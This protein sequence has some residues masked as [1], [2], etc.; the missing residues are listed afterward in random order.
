MNAPIRVPGGAPVSAILVSCATLLAVVLVQPVRANPLPSGQVIFNVQAV[1][2]SF[3]SHPPLSC[4]DAVQYTDQEGILEFDFYVYNLVEPEYTVSALTAEL[5]WPATWIVLDWEVCGSGSGEVQIGSG[6]GSLDLNWP[7][8]P[9]TTNGMFPVMRFIV[10][11][12]GFG[13]FRAGFVDAE[14]GCPPETEPWSFGGGRGQAGVR[15]D[16]CFQPC[17]G[18]EAC[19]PQVDP[20]QIELE[21]APGGTAEREIHVVTGLP[22]L[23]CAYTPIFS[24]TES[25]MSLESLQTSPTD[26][27][28]RLLLDA[29]GLE[30]GDYQGWFQTDVGCRG[31]TRVSLH[32]QTTSGVPGNLP[33]GPVVDIGSWG[34]LKKVF[35]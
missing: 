32:V 31:C 23:D 26:W 34:R 10:E 33:N 35:R 27:D 18:E 12:N 30:E 16:Y 22:W 9:Q 15:C 28:I 20:A 29:A 2:P 24:V 13:E 7:L 3:C 11:V 14:L 17:S 5:D 6:S 21:L 25:W 19:D 8:C 4:H 1:D